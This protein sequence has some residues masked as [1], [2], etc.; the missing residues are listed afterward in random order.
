MIEGARR[1]GKSYIV[2]EFGRNEYEKCL[3]IDFFKAK[4]EVKDLFENYLEDLDD[5]FLRLEVLYDVK[6][7]PRKEKGEEGRTLI[8]FDEVQ[9]CPRARAAIKYLVADGRFDYIE[10]GSLISI[11]KNVKGIMIPSEEHSIDMYPMDFEEF[12]WALGN[13]TL[14]DYARRQFERREEMGPDIHRMAMDYFRKYLIV[15]GMPQAVLKF[16]ETKDFREVDEVKRNILKLYRNDINQYAD[17]QETKVSAIFEE[18]PGQLQRHDRV[19]RLSS[20]KDGARM[21]Q[22]EDA[23]F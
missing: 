13:D 12:L 21:R 8:I 22:Y 17:G 6:L 20:I 5:L 10:T 19:F 15:G 7:I 1:I 9:F 18:I 4:Q 16:I 14:M 3:L 23:F 11:K 2:E